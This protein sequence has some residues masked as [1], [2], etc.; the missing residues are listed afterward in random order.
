[1]EDVDESATKNNIIVDGIKEF[2]VSPHDVN[3]KAYSFRMGK[4]AQNRYYLV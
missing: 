2:P 3:K 1:M 4:G